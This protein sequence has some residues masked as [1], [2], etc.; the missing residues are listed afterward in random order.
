MTIAVRV[1]Q[2]A[3]RVATGA[4]SGLIVLL[5]AAILACGASTVRADSAQDTVDP[6]GAK[7]PPGPIPVPPPAP[8]ETSWWKK[9]LDP[10]QAP[11][12]P[13]PLI[14][15]DPNSGLTLGLLPVWLTSDQNNQITRIV[16][17]DVLY[18]PDFGYGAHGRI[19][20]YA[21]SDEQ[22]SLTAGVKER[23]ERDAD[24]EYQLGRLRESLW[25]VNYS[26][27]FERSGTARFYGI[28]NN[29]HSSAQSDY[30]AEHELAQV[31]VGL[32]FSHDWQ[33]LYTARFQDLDVL[34][35]TLPDLPSIQTRFPD[36]YGLHTHRETLNRLG[37]VYDTRD[38]IVVPSRGMKW[39][40]YSGAASADG[41][42]SDSL[43]TE[44]GIDGRIFWPLATNY[45]LAGHSS[46][47]YLFGSNPVPF[48]ELSNIG[49]GESD[50][51]GAQQLR[52]FG[53]GRY[54]DRDAFSASV[55]LRHKVY[56]LNAVTTDL[57]IE[58]APF[59]D[60]GRVFSQASTS[61]VEHLHQAYGVGFRGI[62]R[63][64]VVGYVDVGV[65]SDGAAVFT[66]LYYPF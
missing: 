56:T 45:V 61:P 12:L 63:P 2:G 25:S 8:A 40:L 49:G 7:V 13:V 57:D 22:W 19:Y 4:A 16:A 27:I 23:V 51:G 3:P 37:L 14:A 50:I 9:W 28:G 54:Y 33:L 53:T 32:N 48:W 31:Q 1:P 59:I 26:V 64:F 6:S 41:V 42:F 58:V 10:S 15:E 62:A 24:F 21:S 30:T 39:A 43:Y 17:P 55:E 60:V 20:E 29:T 52:S 65:G 66:G 44:A 47:H 18:N 46:L 38:D 5:A 35:G 36:V 11:F 34:P